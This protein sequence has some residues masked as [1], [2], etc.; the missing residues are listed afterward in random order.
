MKCVYC[1]RKVRRVQEPPCCV[2]IGK[3]EVGAWHRRASTPVVHE[4][5]PL[6][7]RSASPTPAPAPA[8]MEMVRRARSL[9]FAGGVR[10]DDA[11]FEA[12]LSTIV[13]ALAHP[14]SAPAPATENEERR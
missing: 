2:E 12:K 9:L 11:Q 3:A 8:N 4:E 1:G 5:S 13:A 14:A 7:S 10:Y 6:R